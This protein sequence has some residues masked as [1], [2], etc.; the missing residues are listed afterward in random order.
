MIVVNKENYFNHTLTNYKN[1]LDLLYDYINQV[2]EEML[3]YDFRLTLH[4]DEESTHYVYVRLTYLTRSLWAYKRSIFLRPI[5]DL[6]QELTIFCDKCF[7]SYEGLVDFMEF[8]NKEYFEGKM[9]IDR[10]N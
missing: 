2:Y 8:L 3:G 1:Q 9:T 7:N 10:K 6:L 5:N 4:I